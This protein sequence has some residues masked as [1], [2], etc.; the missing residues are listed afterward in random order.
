MSEK[1]PGTDTSGLTEKD[2]RI[3]NHLAQVS[4][5]AFVILFDCLGS[6][7]EYER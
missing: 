1:T 7:R 6:R 2:H 4:I 5:V 3:L